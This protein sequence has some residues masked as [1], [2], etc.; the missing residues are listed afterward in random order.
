MEHQRRRGDYVSQK[1]TPK[2][3]TGDAERDLTTAQTVAVVRLASGDT[4]TAAAEA[5]GVAR[6]S[7]HRWM[8]DDPV[9]L[10]ALNTARTEVRDAAE[11][12]LLNVAGQASANLQRAVADGNLQASIAVLRG[13]V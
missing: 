3:T 12:R 2:G 8:G 9:F 11:R 6:E 5:A 7:V 4:V 1:V 10:A 13:L